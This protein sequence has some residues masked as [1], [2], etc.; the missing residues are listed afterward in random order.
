MI[1]RKPNWNKWN[2]IDDALVWQ[3]V[4]LSLDI[5]PDEVKRDS[6]DWMAGGRYVNHEGQEFKDRLDV[7]SANYKKI[8]PT[9]KT[10]STNGIAYC[11]INIQKFSKWALLVNW[12]IPDELKQRVATS[13]DFVDL[14]GLDGSKAY[15][16]DLL[17]IQELAINEFF[18]PRKIYDAK[19]DEITE[20]LKLKGKELH[21]EV[22]DN[23]ADAIFTIIKPNDHNPKIR[24]AEP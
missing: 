5:N 15:R 2:L 21:V 9:P 4:A 13:K 8:D 1:N 7:V 20:W 14:N 11:E 22:S 19:K 23:I 24:R 18:N 17:T 12:E 6:G 16:T 3:V 10:L